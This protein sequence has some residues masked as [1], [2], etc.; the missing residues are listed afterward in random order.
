MFPDLATWRPPLC[1]AIISKII[2]KKKERNAVTEKS[3]KAYIY[4]N[5]KQTFEV[6]MKHVL[7]GPSLLYQGMNYHE[8]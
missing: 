4:L 5:I 7:T 2:S 3:S 8:Y 6:K 1:R